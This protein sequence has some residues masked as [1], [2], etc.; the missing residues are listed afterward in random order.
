MV[1]KLTSSGTL[2]VLHAFAGSPAD[3]VS[4]V[5]TLVRDGAGNLYGTTGK[6]GTYDH[7]TVFKVTPNGT[8]TLLQ[9][10]VSGKAD[11]AYP[12]PGLMLDG[13]GNLYGT[14]VLG[15]TFDAGTAFKITATG[16]ESL[17]YSFGAYSGD[18]QHPH[19]GLFRD[20]TG[21]FTEP[22]LTVAPLATA[23]YSS[24]LQGAARPHCTASGD[25]QAMGSILMLSWFKTPRETSMAPPWTAPSAAAPFLS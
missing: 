6:G 5:A 1:F 22:P 18:G 23:R 21:T 17:L 15:G 14:T 12:Y 7:G 11:G 25:I 3:G 4:P 9:S 20:A 10:F 16:D 19:A 13:A 24:W 8:E 2:T